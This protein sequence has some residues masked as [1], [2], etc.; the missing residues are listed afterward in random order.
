[1]KTSILS[2]ITGTEDGIVSKKMISG[3]GGNVTLFAFDSGQSLEKHSTP[4]K[5][6]IMVLEGEATFAKGSEIVKLKKDDFL[7]LLE[8]EEHS[9]EAKTSIKILLVIIKP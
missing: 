3:N 8:N 1:M 9:L 5:A 2:A 6:L 4:H 7:I